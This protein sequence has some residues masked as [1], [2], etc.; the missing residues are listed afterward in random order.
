MKEIRKKLPPEISE[1]D[2]FQN[3]HAE[4]ES[5]LETIRMLVSDDNSTFP[6]YQNHYVNSALR[7]ELAV[8]SATTSTRQP[9]S[10]N[11]S[12]TP[13]FARMEGQTEVTEQFEPGVYVTLI[14]LANGTRIYKGVRFRYVGIRLSH[15]IK[16]DVLQICTGNVDEYS[17]IILFFFP[18][19]TIY[20]H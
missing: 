12:G 9:G 13:E 4:I 16:W 5:L 7:G 14:Q 19:I 2:F 15:I 10:E 6:A 11:G 18:T 17:C 8:S 3:V 1:G 20:K